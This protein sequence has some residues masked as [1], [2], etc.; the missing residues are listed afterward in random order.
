MGAEPGG[1]SDR[2]R[3]AGKS[4]GKGTV[5]L[6]GLG[7]GKGSEGSKALRFIEA[8]D[9]LPPTPPQFSFATDS[10]SAAAFSPPLTSPA[11]PAPAMT[12]A[13]RAELV[14]Q[15]SEWLKS[16]GVSDPLELGELQQCPPGDQGRRELG[17][18]K[19]PSTPS[20]SKGP[21]KK[22]KS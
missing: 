8:L 11:T 6:E 1:G 2:A 13:R 10:F 17:S 19:A 4:D 16:T 3:P 15:R 21:R 9:R 22:G 5:E 20:P 12:P 18:T 14:R 7:G